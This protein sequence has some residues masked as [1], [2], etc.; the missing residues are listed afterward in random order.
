MDVRTKGLRNQGGWMGNHSHRTIPVGLAAR[1]AGW[2]TIS[3]WILTGIFWLLPG[4]SFA[5]LAAAQLRT[6]HLT[7]SHHRSSI[8]LIALGLAFATGSLAEERPAPLSQQFQ[9]EA[10]E[11]K[12]RQSQATQ[13]LRLDAGQRLDLYHL[14]MRQRREQQRLQER[15]RLQGEGRDRQHTPAD[16]RRFHQQQ[17]FQQ[18]RS[19]QLRSFDRQLQ[20]WRTRHQN[21]RP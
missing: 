11:L 15:Q 19:Q 21:L 9:Q 7:V 18:E 4:P 1:L 17:I 16:A 6:R 10:L 8:I 13:G 12:Q 20:Q 3:L 2:L 5:P 14:E